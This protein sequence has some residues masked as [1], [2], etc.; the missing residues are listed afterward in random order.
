MDADLVF[1]V[2]GAITMAAA[3][4]PGDYPR[5]STIR[6]ISFGMPSRFGGP[7]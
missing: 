7:Q 4:R 2:S 1:P 5:V 3:P 6:A